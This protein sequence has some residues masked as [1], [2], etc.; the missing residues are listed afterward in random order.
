M[1]KTQAKRMAMSIKSK[2]ARLFTDQISHGATGA[3]LTV[4]EFSDISKICNRVINK[5]K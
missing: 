4:K 1:T 2:A 3:G 5:L